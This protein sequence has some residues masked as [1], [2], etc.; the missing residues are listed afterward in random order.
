MEGSHW[1]RRSRLRMFGDASIEDKVILCTIPVQTMYIVHRLFR[2]LFCFLLTLSYFV[3]SPT[4][5]RA[6]IDGTATHADWMVALVLSDVPSNYQAQFC[7]GTLVGRQW[8]LTAAHCTYDPA[9]RPYAAREFQ[10]VVGQNILTNGAADRL[11]VE[12]IVRHPAFNLRNLHADVA[13]LHLSHPVDRSPVRIIVEEALQEEGFVFGWGVTEDGFSSAILKK[14]QLAL[15]GAKR[16]QQDIAQEG[17]RLT[18]TMLCLLTGS[19]RADSC[20][21]DSGGP[22]VQIDAQGHVTQVGIISWGMG[23]GAADSFGVYTD[24]LT[25]GEWINGILDREDHYSFE[26][27]GVVKPT[28]I[29]GRPQFELVTALFRQW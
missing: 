25:V 6:I 29:P 13:L 12:S 3:F 23:C 16:C 9:G 28:A 5:S 2:A 14:T 17:Y 27:F 24:M 22:I 11:P 18:E 19:S 20:W 7:G 1:L 8:V 4:E 21:G 10:A 15:A 26:G